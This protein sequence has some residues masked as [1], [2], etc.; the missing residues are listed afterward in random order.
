LKTAIDEAPLS[1]SAKNILYQKAGIDPSAPAKTGG[2][3]SSA[4]K[5]VENLFSS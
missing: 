4:A 2:I 3:F 1:E 5:F